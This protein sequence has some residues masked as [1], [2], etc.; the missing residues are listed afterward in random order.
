MTNT[1]A[2]NTTR[3]KEF[4]VR[5][6]LQA[7]GLH[8]WV[9]LRLMSKYVKER[10]ES[11]W[12]DKPYIGKLIFCVIPAIYYR[13]VVE[14]KHVI[15]KP[16]ELSRLDI[17]GMPASGLRMP[18]YGLNDFKASVEAEYADAAR[19]RDI[20]GYQ[21]QYQPG[22]ALEMLAGPFEG[23]SA[24]FQSVIRRAFDAYPKLR[25]TIDLLGRPVVFEV[26]PDA[27]RQAT[28]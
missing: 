24:A 7:M 18:R 16:L 14:L 23:A 20:S 15:G 19:A 8:P 22:Q 1:Y 12:Y 25:V 5:D 9:P 21:C 26:D 13:D 4:E 10:R 6:E 11:V 3:N 27:V 28:A 17:V 2:I